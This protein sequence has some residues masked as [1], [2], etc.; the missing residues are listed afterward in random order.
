MFNKCPGQ[1]R[2]FWGP[3]DVYDV[4]CLSCGYKVEFFKDEIKLKCPKCK[5]EIMNPKLDL[6]CAIWCPSAKD[7]IGPDRY[8]YITKTVER[9]NLRRKDFDRFIKTI[10]KKDS[11]VKELFIKLYGKNK[12]H[13]KLFD[14][15]ELRKIK[16]Q[17]PKFFERASKYNKDFSK[18]PS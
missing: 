18:N 9:E 1:N 3:D 5:K 16:E 12:D 13:R 17:D 10:D 11:D 14:T 4:Q 6:G 2:Q 15:K 8:N 7:C